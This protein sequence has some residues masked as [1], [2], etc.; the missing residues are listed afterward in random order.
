MGIPEESGILTI[1]GC[2]IRIVG[3]AEQEFLYDLSKKK[4]IEQYSNNNKNSPQ[5]NQQFI[6]HKYSGLQAIQNAN[7]KQG[8]FFLF[9]KKKKK[10]YKGK[11]SIRI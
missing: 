2:T 10:K 5:S 4:I 7:K 3:F 6:K 8:R 1:R 11:K 9:F